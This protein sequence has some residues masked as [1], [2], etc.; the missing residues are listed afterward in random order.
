MPTSVDCSPDTSKLFPG[1][2]T[3]I[4]ISED[5]LLEPRTTDK[6]DL[7]KSARILTA[8]SRLVSY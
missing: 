1:M 6:P 2:V 7:M 3:G 5:M 8:G 4:E